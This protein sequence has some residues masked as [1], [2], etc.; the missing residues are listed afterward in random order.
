VL[1]LPTST[2]K[3]DKH[4]DT[5]TSSS[6]GAETSSSVGTGSSTSISSGRST[7]SDI[8]E[9]TKDPAEGITAGVK[10]AYLEDQRERAELGD[11]KFE[12][13]RQNRAK[14]GDEKLIAQKG[15]GQKIM[16]GLQSVAQTATQGIQTGI[17]T[18]S[19]MIT[20]SKAETQDAEVQSTEVRK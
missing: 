5:E 10:A 16:E 6:V 20:G 13:G 4:K 11:E 15:I 19:H 18:A 7:G 8:G 1:K 14:E 2:S 3:K 12:Q 9:Q 17:Q